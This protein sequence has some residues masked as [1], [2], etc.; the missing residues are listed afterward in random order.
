MVLWEV[1]TG[2]R[3]YAGLNTSQIIA[4]VS[5][6]KALQVPSQC[7]GPLRA[8]VQACVSTKPSDRP[9]FSTILDILDEVEKEMAM[10]CC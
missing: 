2:H 1:V 9:A 7:P 4:Q 6:G 3:P 5:S 10:F 8:L